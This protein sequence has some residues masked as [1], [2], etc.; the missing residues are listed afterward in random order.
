M[1]NSIVPTADSLT[2]GISLL[3][4]TAL[5]ARDHQPSDLSNPFL[6]GPGYGSIIWN[7]LLLHH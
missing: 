7:E 1:R 2:G 3:D 5:C 6:E 4:T